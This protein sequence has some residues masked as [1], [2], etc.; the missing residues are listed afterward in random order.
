MA[1]LNK[2]NR[3][4]AAEFL[5]PWQPPDEFTI[6]PAK[7][8]SWDDDAR[9]IDWVSY[10][11]WLEADWQM[12]TGE[13]LKWSEE[14]WAMVA[15]NDDRDREPMLKVL[16]AGTASGLFQRFV[17]DQI[18][19]NRFH[20]P[21]TSSTEKAANPTRKAGSVLRRIKGILRSSYPTRASLDV[22]FRAATIAALMYGVEDDPPD[23]R[24]KKE[25]STK[26]E[27]VQTE[28]KGRGKKK[29]PTAP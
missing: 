17:A 13:W 21:A 9:L 1:S 6:P 5:P 23:V 22:D 14:K 15:W 25:P 19:N 12:P 7:P 29:S 27:K 3:P 8:P 26:E 18:S 24:G 28:S 2:G 20:G 10:H 16:E 11:L 4:L